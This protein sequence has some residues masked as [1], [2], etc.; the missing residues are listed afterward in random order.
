MTAAVAV[1]RTA[2]LAYSPRS[3]E[4]IRRVLRT[5]G[6]APLVFTS[7]DEL[8]A[9]G[10]D[11]ATLDLM[12]LGDAPE[13]DS[14]ARDVAQH[15]LD[16]TRGNV[17]LLHASMHRPASRSR[18]RDA[19]SGI[20]AVS[21][22]FFSELY[23]VILSFVD[24]LGFASAPRLLAWD[25]YSFHPIERV[26]VFDGQKLKLD[27][28]DFDIALELFFNAGRPLA[29]RWLTRMLPAGEHGAN[30]HRIDN[31]GC[32][33]E[34]LREALQLHGRN[35]WLLEDLPDGGCQLHAAPAAPRARAQPQ[36]NAHPA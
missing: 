26:V 16:A 17:P 35:G 32:T 25:R 10:A 19:A 15:V 18:R 8:M 28:V 6:Y 13:I 36:R 22:R 29:R 34:D 30:W 23:R 33:I 1:R 20:G 27:A 9:M 5:L 24:S 12:V 2:V 3:R 7:L 4:Y 11:A 14:Q 21:P 31:L